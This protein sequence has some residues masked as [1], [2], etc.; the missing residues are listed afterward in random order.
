MTIYNFSGISPGDIEDCPTER[1]S[2]SLY[3]YRCKRSQRQGLRHPLGWPACA[4][5]PFDQ[6]SDSTRKKLKSPNPID[7]TIRVSFILEHIMNKWAG[8]GFTS[9]NQRRH[10]I[11]EKER[12]A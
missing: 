12:R 5:C 3:R 4:A 11:G 1:T 7:S 10:D 2:K 6:S 9:R 8:S